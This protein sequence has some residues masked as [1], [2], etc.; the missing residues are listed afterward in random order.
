MKSA[1]AASLRDRREAAAVDF[2]RPNSALIGS[3]VEIASQR[4]GLRVLDQA[5]EPVWDDDMEPVLAISV[6]GHAK[7]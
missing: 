6:P 4:R 1:A 5:V 7:P 3:V 2:A